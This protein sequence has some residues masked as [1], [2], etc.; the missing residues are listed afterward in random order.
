MAKKS[1]RRGNGEGSIIKLSG[2][3]RKPYAV[4]V[5]VGW[6]VEGKQKY[7]YVSYHEKIKKW[8]ESISSHIVRYIKR[9]FFNNSFPFQ[10]LHDYPCI[11]FSSFP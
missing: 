10:A 9:L 1:I 6:T 5:T 11:R 2:K 4:R 7:K 8:L 3:R